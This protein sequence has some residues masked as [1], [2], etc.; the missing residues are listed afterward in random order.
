[1]KTFILILFSLLTIY[2]NS[3]TIYSWPKKGDPEWLSSN[4]S[5]NT[6]GYHGE[7]NDHNGVSTS[8]KGE[9]YNNN[10]I[11]TYT[12]PIF[13]LPFEIEVKMILGIK[14]KDTDLNT[15]YD[16][17]YFQYSLNGG[18]TWINPVPRQT[19]VN[20]SQIDLNS[21][22]LGQNQRT[23]WSGNQSE[24]EVVSCKF[25]ASN[26][27]V[28]RYVFASNDTINKGNGDGDIYHADIREFKIITYNL[29]P[30]H[31]VDFRGF[32]EGNTNILKWTTLSEENIDYFKILRSVDGIIYDEIGR[33]QGAGTSKFNINYEFRDENP[34]LGTNYYKFIQ[35]DYDDNNTTSN[36]IS[37][38]NIN[39]EVKI[40]AIYDLSGRVVNE[41]FS[42]I[43]I[44]HYSNGEI[45][46][47]YNIQ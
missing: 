40:I 46:K 15:C 47:V 44:I 22:G 30:I 12:S 42:G 38:E 13:D 16:W 4:P 1:M 23:G 18:E 7:N 39:T 3:Q 5:N 29:L 28:F 20:N 24:H 8:L 10:Q 21:Y 25:R 41:D 33:L 32:N 9:T 26:R 35:V 43:K 45:K 19:Y 6:L 34:L 27:T 14:L 37:V 36:V 11:T 31:Y 17:L 2:S